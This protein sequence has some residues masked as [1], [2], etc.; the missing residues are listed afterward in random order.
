[1]T[2]EDLL[3]F[4]DFDLLVGL[5]RVV[6]VILLLAQMIMMEQSEIIEEEHVLGLPPSP[7]L[8]V[9]IAIDGKGSSK[10]LVQ[11]ALE[12]FMPQGK[13]AFKLLHICPK[14]TAVPTPSKQ[15][16]SKITCRNACLLIVV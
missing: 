6:A 11:W 15:L 1:L 12:K 8:T 2:Y 9:G 16:L 5:T 7:P 3:L 14:I 13:V 10:Y 4:L